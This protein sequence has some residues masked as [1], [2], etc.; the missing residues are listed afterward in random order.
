MEIITSRNNVKIKYACSLK[1]ASVRTSENS[2]LAEGARLCRDAAESGIR[3]KSLFITQKQLNSESTLPVIE[4]ADNVFCIEKHV[5][6][7]LA[8]TKNSQGIFAVCEKPDN[9]RDFDVNGKYILL[10]NLSN[11]SNLGAIV[12]TAEALGMSGAVLYECCDV[13][14]PK[15]LRA[16][17]G[18]AFRFPIFRP[19]D[20]MRFLEEKKSFGMKLYCC[21]VDGTAEDIRCAD[22][23]GGIIAAVGNEANGL[24][25]K[26]KEAG[27]CVTIKMKGRAESMNAS[28]AAAVVMH[29]IMNRAD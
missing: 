15:A 5:A 8:D 24:S 3:I 29:E 6:E 13:F 2:F 27:T 12:R 28:Q 4:A 18:S 7:K 16:T 26:L 20:F 10:E 22:K 9:S 23:T 11:P 25:R 14:S 17:M 1:N 21:V 19:R